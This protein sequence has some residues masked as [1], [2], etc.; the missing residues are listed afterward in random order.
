[1]IDF[2]DCQGIFENIKSQY[3]AKTID[4]FA[5]M[6]KCRTDASLADKTLSQKG[7]DKN[8]I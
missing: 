3:K 6:Y 4:A 7:A 8:D 5:K 2:M 1:M